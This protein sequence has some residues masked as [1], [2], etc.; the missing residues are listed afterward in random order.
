MRNMK[1]LLRL[2]GAAALTTVAAS[3]VVACGT[4]TKAPALNGK[5]AT[6]LG[7]YSNENTSLINQELKKDDTA[8]KESYSI[9]VPAAD[10]TKITATKFNEK[11][12]K[13][14]TGADSDK[15]QAVS[16]DAAAFLKDLG[17][18]PD[19]KKFYSADDVKKITALSAKVESTEAGK[20]EAAG[21]TDFKVEAG[22]CQINIMDKA[23]GDDAKSV[24]K[25]T[26]NTLKKDA[27]GVPA[28]VYTLVELAKLDLT[29][30]NG[31]EQGKDVLKSLP[32]K[33]ANSKEKNLYN[34]LVNLFSKDK[35][36]LVWTSDDQGQ[37]V[38]P[39]YTDQK[40]YLTVKFGEVK[41]INT[42]DFGTPQA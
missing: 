23:T 7:W 13:A 1:T 12:L 2:M 31:F 22:T 32:W 19:S 30:A 6:L 20:I 3:S 38:V 8:G 10:N 9:S 24:K 17:F 28:A 15:F 5:Y 26:I 42:L 11:L 25:Y 39:K 36:S 16:D 35:V 41:V 40:V 21:T 37:T 33:A 4:Q 27:L 18:T 34:S 29:K 14:G